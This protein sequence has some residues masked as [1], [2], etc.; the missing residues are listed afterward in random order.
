MRSY[1]VCGSLEHNARDANHFD[2][3]LNDVVVMCVRYNADEE[4][5]LNKLRQKGPV[6]VDGVELEAWRA[7]SF[8]EI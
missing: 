2:V 6:S 5:K 3:S 7:I 1:S 8:F 4:Q